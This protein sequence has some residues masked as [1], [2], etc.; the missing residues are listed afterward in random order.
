LNDRKDYYFSIPVQYIGDYQVENFEFNNG[1]ILIGDYEI[2]LDRDN[3]SI[4]MLVNESSDEL[5]G[6]NQY[7]I[8]VEYTL[9]NNEIDNIINEYEKGNT[10]SKFYLGYT[11]TIDDEQMECGYLDDFELYN[12]EAARS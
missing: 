3:V 9:K 5:P 4:D 12:E 6:L 2:L 7:D 8:L 11:I 1:Y 10:Y